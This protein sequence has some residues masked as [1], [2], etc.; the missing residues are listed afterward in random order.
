MQVPVTT[1]S[2]TLVMA[3][4]NNDRRRRQ[5]VGDNKPQWGAPEQDEATA[6]YTY[7]PLMSSKRHQWGV[8]A[9]ISTAS[10]SDHELHL[11]ESL[12]KA[13]GDFHLFECEAEALKR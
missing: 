5:G 4:D 6:P 7:N 10:P 13:L 2:G 1:V 12:L 11:T 3:K 9:P 8:T